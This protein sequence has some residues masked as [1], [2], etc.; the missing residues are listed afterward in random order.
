MGAKNE[1]KNNKN[2]FKSF[3]I[4]LRRPW[5]YFKGNDFCK[6]KFSLKFKSFTSSGCK[7]KDLETLSLR[8]RFNSFGI[9]LNN[10]PH[11]IVFLLFLVFSLSL[12][13]TCIHCI[14]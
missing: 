1:S 9:F 8:Q 7:D 10:Y 5:T 14:V 4:K 12:L 13:Y 2:L 11:T 6:K 3:Y